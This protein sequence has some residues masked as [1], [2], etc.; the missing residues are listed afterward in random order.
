VKGR[1]LGRSSA[2]RSSLRRLASGSL[3]NDKIEE[4]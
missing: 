2:V 4:T 1:A 3:V